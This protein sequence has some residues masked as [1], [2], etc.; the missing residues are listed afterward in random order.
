MDKGKHLDSWKDIAAYLGRNVRTCRNWERDLGLP[1]H[2]LEGSPKSHV[3]AYSGEIDAWRDEKGRLP[4]NGANGP[5]DGEPASR[6]SPPAMVPIRRPVRTWLMAGL[7]ATPLLAI[8][9]MALITRHFRPALGPA[10]GRF[11]IK[12]EPSHRLEGE[13]VDMERPSRTAMAI[14]GDGKL[15]VYSAIEENPG[16]QAKP[17]LY[18][19]RRDQSAAKPIAGTEGGLNPFLSPDGRWVGFW[20]DSKLKKVL[21][22]GGVPR[23]LCDLSDWLYGANWGRDN[24]IV[25]ADGAS[26]GLSRVSAEGGKPEILTKPDPKREEVSHRL[27]SWLP[28][29]KAVLFTVMK[30]FWDPK[31]RLALLRLDTGERRVLLEDAADA[32]YVPTG[33][34]V[35]LAQGTLMAVRF[36]PARLE[37]IGQPAALVEN[38]MQAIG[39]SSFWYHTGAGQLGIS[40]TGSLIYA[41]GGVSPPMYDSLVWVDQRGVER[42]VTDLRFPYF[43]PRLSPDG[44]RIAYTTAGPEWQVY[45]YD[46]DRG[47]NS[48]LTDEGFSAY[49]IWAPNGDRL[50]FSWG[51]TSVDSLYWQPR[52]GSS[53]MERLTTSEY[54]QRPGSW[55]SDGKMLAFVDF[56]PDTGADISL[57]DVGSK[58]VTPF[59]NSPFREEYPE[60]SPDGRW[61]VYSSDES[62]NEEIY[63]RAF[64]GPG[65]KQQVSVEG[66][67][68]PLWARNGKQ[69]FYRWGDQV[70]VVDVRTNGGLAT[71]KPRLLFEKPGY[72][73]GYPIRAWDL[74]LDSQRFLMIK[75]EQR[76]PTPVTEMVLVENW[77]EELKRLVPNG[78]K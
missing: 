47:T 33:H 39:W 14:S 48:R 58:R 66:G 27:P 67:D 25:F 44:R 50:L 32:R 7:M 11:T 38:V 43:A 75:S 73:S 36:D 16:P 54:G 13:A 46:L 49:A 64:P 60:F 40:D 22:E 8:V 77:F 30:G 59:L 26:S 19:R 17:Q 52:D 23:T 51:R 55:S 12:I 24:S 53:P 61:M 18:L 10:V 56:H 65:P 20:A 2:R 76:K 4:G 57:L 63:I 45:V 34:L 15:I 70:W 68:Q 37:V 6:P 62:K 21:V 78:K 31:P 28:N 5:G 35:F 69:L 42:P 41:P 3:F 9:T 29:G 72:V 74:S 71:A 1:V